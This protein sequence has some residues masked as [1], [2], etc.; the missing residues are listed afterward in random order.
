[1]K[2]ITIGMNHER[3]LIICPLKWEARPVIKALGL[4][5]VQQSPY[6][7]YEN[8]DFVLVISGVGELNAS[9][10]LS[11]TVGMYSQ[12]NSPIGSGVLFGVGG[13]SSI[14]KG[15]LCLGY[16]ISREG[17]RD[18][19][20]PVCIKNTLTPVTVCTNDTPV[21]AQDAYI[22][23]EEGE[24]CSLTT[25]AGRVY[26]MEGYGFAQAAAALLSPHAVSVVRVIS[27]NLS[28]Y[29]VTPNDISTICE[30]EID[31][32]CAYLKDFLLFTR[33][34]THSREKY[35]TPLPLYVENCMVQNRLTATQKAQIT[36]SVRKYRVFF[37]GEE[38]AEALFSQRVSSPRERNALVLSICGE[39]NEKCKGAEG[40]TCGN[41]D[42]SEALQKILLPHFFNVYIEEGVKADSN[43]ALILSRLKRG[44]VTFVRHYKDVFNI[45]QRGAY[46]TSLSKP[47]IFARTPGQ[48]LYKGSRMC[49]AFGAEEFYY[50]S[51]MFGCPYSC[52]YC[53]LKGQ[54]TSSAV[55]YFTD[56][57]LLEGELKGLKPGSLVC[58]SYE[59][60]VLGLQGLLGSFSRW[61]E[62]AKKLP[63]IEF[64]IRTKA[65][66]TESLYKL[67]PLKNVT[68]AWS[69]APQR[70]SAGLERCAPTLK[71][72]LKSA[73]EAGKIGW[74]VRLCA[75]P[76]VY[77]QS[78]EEDCELLVREMV[79]S[80]ALEYC[81]D[82]EI[83]CLRISATHVSARKR[84][85]PSKI[86]L[87]PYL[88]TVSEGGEESLTYPLKGYMVDFLKGCI[89]KY[90]PDKRIFV[91]E[92]GASE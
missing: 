27:D 43:T 31:G 48:M 60:E 11:Y 72:R 38:P 6:R 3:C 91:Y 51:D 39:I 77:T 55:V 25:S 23:C 70:V 89:E 15:E 65:P 16:K 30:G 12:S 5:Q 76:L 83:G 50:A 92:E 4:T 59:S 14:G 54:F 40:L 7:I 79:S 2:A 75:E 10:A 69:I 57:D 45:S 80:E 68:L 19:Y 47:L 20:P 24:Y 32:L 85:P 17:K 13:S 33:E 28:P 88:Q 35:N 18:I 34:I 41:N 82:I 46:A 9:N 63:H 21:G 53:W 58:C 73:C 86:M 36:D 74:G 52:E 81:K 78:F 71:A 56:T 87:S 62:I 66:F 84:Y 90:A 44:V 49:N 1:M 26:D 42:I 61:Y 64:E 37:N 8:G 67:P 22:P 29:S